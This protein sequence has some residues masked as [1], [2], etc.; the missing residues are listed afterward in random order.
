MRAERCLAYFQRDALCYR[1][2]LG[3]LA[4]SC[5]TRDVLVFVIQHAR[6]FGNQGQPLLADALDRLGERVVH[7]GQ[8]VGPV[9]HAAANFSPVD[10]TPNPP[11]LASRALVMMC[12]N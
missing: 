1:E 12:C 7:F 4:Y 3:S 10:R 6:C 5:L 2:P 9:E 11:C 8:P